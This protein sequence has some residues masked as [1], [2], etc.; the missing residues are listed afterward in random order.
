MERI[1]RELRGGCGARG[2]KH[3]WEKGEDGML[4]ERF[5]GDLDKFLEDL[6]GMMTVEQEGK[7]EE[8]EEKGGGGVCINYPK[9]IPSYQVGAAQVGADQ[10]ILKIPVPGVPSSPIQVVKEEGEEEIT[11]GGKIEG[12]IEKSR[13]FWEGEEKFVNK[14]VM[15]KNW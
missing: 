7:G 11:P 10:A 2:V 3:E 6:K 4:L 5:G 15:K 14:F 13:E 1:R 8:I 12:I 9:Y